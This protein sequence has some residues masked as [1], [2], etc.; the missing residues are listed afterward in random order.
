MIDAGVGG[1]GRRANVRNKDE[2]GHEGEVFSEGFFYRMDNF[3]FITV[4][5]GVDKKL[6]TRAISPVFKLCLTKNCGVYIYFF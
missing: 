4:G 5:A 3:K 1:D 6:G 2:V